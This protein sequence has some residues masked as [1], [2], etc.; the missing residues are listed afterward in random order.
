[1]KNLKNAIQILNCNYFIPIILIMI[2]T[3]IHQKLFNVSK[4]ADI[5]VIKTAYY[6]EAKKCHPELNPHDPAATARFQKLAAAYEVLSD[7]RKRRTYDATGDYIHV[8]ICMCV[9]TCICMYMFIC[10]F[11][12]M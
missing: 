7:D 1:M 3:Y 5:K 6:K 10:V 12:R 4:T 9:Y 8:Y 11:V 2:Y